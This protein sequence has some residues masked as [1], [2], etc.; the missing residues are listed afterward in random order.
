MTIQDYIF[1]FITSIG[2]TSS[3]LLIAAFLGKSL[4]SNLFNREL[5]KIKAQLSI[6]VHEKNIKISRLDKDKADAVKRIH[7]SLANL[8]NHAIMVFIPF[9]SISPKLDVILQSQCDMGNKFIAFHKSVV[10]FQYELEL[11]SI[12]LDNSLVEE[13]NEAV[14]RL[15]QNTHDTVLKVSNY[16]EKEIRPIEE[17][18]RNLEFLWNVKKIFENSFNETFYP[19]RIKLINTFRA[20]LS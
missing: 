1:I 11:Y 10:H 5:E 12:Y 8:E 13:I 4:L 18:E 2:G 20:L 17:N 15:K 14:I 19:L 16:I 9:I 7:F 6:Q 3:I